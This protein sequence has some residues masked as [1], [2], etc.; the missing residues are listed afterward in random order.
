M[1]GGGLTEMGAE[2]SNGWS[3]AFASQAP[4]RKLSAQHRVSL[5]AQSTGIS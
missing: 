5:E 3:V 4:G 2:A 1:V